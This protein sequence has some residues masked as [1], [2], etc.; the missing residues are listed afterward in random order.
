M[1]VPTNWLS[2]VY[3]VIMF[4]TF[5]IFLI[6]PFLTWSILYILASI[7]SVLLSKYCS[8]II[9][10]ATVVSQPFCNTQLLF[11][12]MLLCLNTREL[13]LV[14]WLTTFLPLFKH[15]A[16]SSTHYVKWS[17]KLLCN[18]DMCII[19]IIVLNLVISKVTFSQQNWCIYVCVC[20]VNNTLV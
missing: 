7:Y 16:T 13:T 18:V 3:I 17:I 6:C 20:W 12:P 2:L 15:S 8:L 14:R 1:S 19:N 9:C 11:P 5:V 10:C 4:S